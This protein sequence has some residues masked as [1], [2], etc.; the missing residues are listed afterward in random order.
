[1][2]I[3]TSFATAVLF[4]MA[5]G[6]VAP[7]QAQTTGSSCIAPINFYSWRSV[8]DRTVVLTDKTRHDWRV[9][10]APGCFNLDFAMGIGVKSFTTSRLQCISRGDYVV[11]PRDVGISGERCLITKVEP[12]TAEMAHDDAVAKAM[13]QKP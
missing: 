11:V 4:A 9:S 10:L 12:Y 5:L 3:K 2:T 7:A 1:M 13:K 6:V 8:N